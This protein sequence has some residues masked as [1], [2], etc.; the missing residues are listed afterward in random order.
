MAISVKDVETLAHLARIQLTAQEM[1][2]FAG[3]LDQILAYVQKLKAAGTQGV[4]PMSHVLELA[5]VFREDQ[6]QPS[7]SV[8]EALSNAPEREG[9]FFKVPRII[10]PA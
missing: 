7:L 4:A 10:D 5:N 3:Q 1:E 2:R 8:D 9:S 6:V